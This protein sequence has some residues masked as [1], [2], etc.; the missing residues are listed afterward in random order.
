MMKKLRQNKGETLIEAMVSLLIALLSM[1]LLSTCVLAAANINADTR[2][3]DEKYN[4]ELQTAEG[5]IEDGYTAEEV[6]VELR[7][8]SVETQ[9]ATV[10]LYGPEDSAFAA[11]DYEAEETQP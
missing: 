11:Y 8:Q 9:T 5:L 2:A 1:G 3:A 7:F 6:T 10:K 4:S